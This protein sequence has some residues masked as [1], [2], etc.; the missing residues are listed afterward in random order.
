MSNPLKGRVKWFDSK[1]GFGFVTGD[2][3]KDYFVHYSVIQS[4]GFKTLQ[5]GEPVEFEAQAGPKGPSAT[6]VTSLTEKKSESR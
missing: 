1:K 3:G 4:D 5:E 6:R 2:D